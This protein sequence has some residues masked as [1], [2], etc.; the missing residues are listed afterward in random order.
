MGIALA[1]HTNPKRCTGEEQCELDGRWVIKRP[2]G[3]GQRSQLEA[4][5]QQCTPGVSR[6]SHPV[7]QLQ[8]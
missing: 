2:E 1:T 6:G 7:Q 8:E 5:H 4:S 3:G